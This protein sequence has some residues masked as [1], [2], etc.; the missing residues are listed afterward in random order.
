MKVIKTITRVFKVTRLTITA[1]L[2]AAMLMLNIATIAF[3][4]VAFILSAA[5]EAVT[6]V[7]SVTSTLRDEIKGKNKRIANLEV[8]IRTKDGRISSLSDELVDTK[9]QNSRLNAD[10]NL[11]NGQ[12]AS[13][14]DE[15]GGLRNSSTVTYRNQ[16]VLL[17]D[18]VEHT[19]ERISAR[20]LR[21][22]AINFNSMA[23]EAIP[24]L[25]VAVIVSVT[26]WDIKSSC[27]TM[28]DL[29]ELDVAFNP[30]NAVSDEHS[31]VCGLT[32]P[33]KG[34]LLKMAKDSPGKAWSAAKELMPELPEFKLPSF[35]W[36]FGD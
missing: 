16:R 30:N 8:D 26:A 7:A 20:T 23:A 10:V 17:S 31:E 19:A 36:P 5:F 4:S 9:L 6:G 24:Y 1:T 25:G 21:G 14:T 12:I 3:S 33:T 18:A 22:A 34:E 32:I 2:L 27:D 11:K 35:D 15:V 29:H 13:L 28:N